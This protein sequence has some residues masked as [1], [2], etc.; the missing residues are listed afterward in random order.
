MDKK[1]ELLNAIL[2][3]T[4]NGQSS[5]DKKRLTCTK[6][7]ELAK[8]CEMEIIEIGRIC[9]K[10]NIKICKCQLGCFE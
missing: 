9:N 7:F 1:E 5:S 8:N 3:C 6:A 10:H 2:K 4:S